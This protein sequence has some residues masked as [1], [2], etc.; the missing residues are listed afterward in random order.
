M[1]T[2]TKGLSRTAMK[3]ARSQAKPCL[4]CGHG[5]PHNSM[6]PCQCGCASRSK[7]KNE[8]SKCGSG[9][10]H[11]SVSEAMWCDSLVMME[12]GG[13]IRGLQQQ[14]KHNLYLGVASIAI[15]LSAESVAALPRHGKSGVIT[16]FITPL[17]GWCSCMGDK[18]EPAPSGLEKIGGIRPDWE[19]EERTQGDLGED[20]HKVTADAKGAQKDDQARLYQIF[21]LVHG[22]PVVLLKG[23]PR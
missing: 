16:K 21:E 2:R 15:G 5:G 14:V 4:N 1:L 18:H 22:R 3:R 20:W 10:Y 12:K 11:A 8:R 13:A 23:R 9:H 7:Y 17:I 6:M 19:Y